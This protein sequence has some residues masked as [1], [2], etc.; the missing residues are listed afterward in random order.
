MKGNSLARFLRNRDSFGH[1]VQLI[2]KGNETYNSLFGGIVT[3]MVQALTLIMVIQAVTELASMED[4][5]I[6]NYPKPLTIE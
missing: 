2:Y 1:A 5:L 3:L 6:I 4:P